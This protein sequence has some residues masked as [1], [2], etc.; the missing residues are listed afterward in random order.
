MTDTKKKKNIV[1]KV[2]GGGEF[3]TYREGIA[4]AI[5]EDWDD[6]EY[7]NCSTTSSHAVHV[8]LNYDF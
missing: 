5:D 7:V 8:G 1:R 2:V 6:I 3:C 4:H